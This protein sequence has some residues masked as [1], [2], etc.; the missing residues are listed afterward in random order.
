MEVHS[1]AVT[2]LPGRSMVPVPA[3]L[4]KAHIRV[5]VDLVACTPLALYNGAVF[6]F[7]VIVPCWDVNF[8]FLL[9]EV[10]VKTNTGLEKKGRN[11]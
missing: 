8:R 5:P 2:D 6:V 3:A 4:H 9:D 1:E 10:V 7:V 11:E